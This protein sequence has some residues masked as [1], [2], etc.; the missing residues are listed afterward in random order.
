MKHLLLTAALSGLSLASAQTAPSNL[1]GTLTL[2]T[3]EVQA[4]VQAQVDAFK[5]RYPKVDVQLFRSGTGEVTAKLNAELEAGNPQADLLW[6]AD[7]TYFDTL[8]KRNLL[9]KLNL[10]G[11]KV[12]ASAVYGDTSAEVRKLYNVI[13]VNT[14]VLKT[15]PKSFAD[16]KLPAYQNKLAMPNP[17]FSGGALS[18]AGTL[19]QQLSWDYFGALA[20]NGMKIE[21]SNPITTTKLINGE[22]GAAL[23]VDYALRREM[24]K[25]A[26]IEVVYPSEGA[27]LVPTPIGV[28]KSSKHKA[29]AQ[30]FVRF[31]YSPTAQA[32]FAKLSY[33]PVMP[34]APRPAG[35][36]ASIPTL[37]SAAAYIAT[38]KAEIGQRFSALFDLK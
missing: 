26:P 22:Y 21:Q 28:L 24:A 31:L 10:I 36:P 12:P 9:E 3:S 7:Q 6:V 34:G 1:S 38:N 29:L 17:L 30:A 18:T 14:N 35:V 32:N 11:L 4:D 2:Y 8:S 15:I 33:V 20:K 5:Q 23:L 19:A 27:I 16:L 25:G 13:G 37:P